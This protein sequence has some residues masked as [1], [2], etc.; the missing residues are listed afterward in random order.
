VDN[1]EK[2]PRKKVLVSED[3][4]TSKNEKNVDSS[5]VSSP[6]NEQMDA[7]EA[8]EPETTKENWT[9]KEKDS[10]DTVLFQQSD[11][12]VWDEEPI[13]DTVIWDEEEP[14]NGI[15]NWDESETNVA[16]S[17]GDT[18]LFDV[19]LETIF[20]RPRGGKSF[21]DQAVLDHDATPPFGD[22]MVLYSEPIGFDED[23][24]L[25]VDN[26]TEN[27]WWDSPCHYDEYEERPSAVQD[28]KDQLLVIKEQ[29]VQVLTRADGAHRFIE[30]LIWKTQME[31]R[32]KGVASGVTSAQLCI[33]KEALE[34]MEL[35]YLQLFMDRNLALKFSEDKEREVEELCYQ[36][37]LARSSSLTEKTPTSLAV[38]IHEGVN[39]THDFREESL[40]MIPHEEHSKLYVLEERYDTDGFDYAHVMHCGPWGA[41]SFGE[42]TKGS[43]LSFEGDS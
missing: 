38:M 21:L 11:S 39:G 23:S 15:V 42:T 32:Q 19:N 18:N 5:Y 40:V 22:C 9:D 29:I 12:V 10:S 43:R 4:D 41:V 17:M 20:D 30:D 2:V 33:I 28:L 34:Q 7:H 31:E 24:V 26:K 1:K 3:S 25:T 14:I 13:N 8:L 36:L 37:R 27:Q 35:D 16:D 6:A